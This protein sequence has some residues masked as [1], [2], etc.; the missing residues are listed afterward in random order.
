MNTTEPKKS[1]SDP[2]KP[3]EDPKAPR[4]AEANQGEGNRTADREYREGLKKHLETHD[5]DAE[6]KEA[7]KALDD[8]KQRK[9][10]EEAEAAARKG[11]TVKH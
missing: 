7:E 2:K 4:R 8:P 3:A 9:E 5:V 6:A 11:K 1:P 10:L